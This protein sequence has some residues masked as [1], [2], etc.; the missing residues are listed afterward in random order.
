MRSASSVID[1]RMR[2]MLLLMVSER[3]CLS[4]SCWPQS[5]IISFSDPHGDTSESELSKDY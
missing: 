3:S 5:V 4:Y 1:A 2:L